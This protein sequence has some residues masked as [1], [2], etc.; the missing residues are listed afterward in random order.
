[1]LDRTQQ[2]L[3]LAWK[4]GDDMMAGNGSDAH[5][6]K[7]RRFRDAALPHLDAVY[8][9]ANY[10][11]HNTADAE[12]A[13]QECYLRA[14]RHFDT[15]RNSDIK[16]WLFAILRNV[17]RAEYARRSGVVLHVVGAEA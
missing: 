14:L 15:V 12:D 17:C 10:L 7:A 13:V 6:D 5:Q 9:L 11:L 1:M 16:P 8:T 4:A 3:A 2:G